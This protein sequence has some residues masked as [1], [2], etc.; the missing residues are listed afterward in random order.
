MLQNE[1]AEA[2]RGQRPITSL[3][4]SGKREFYKPSDGV[5]SEDHT[6]EVMRK[7]SPA[8]GLV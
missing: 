1:E 3:C 4:T 5:L 7:H 6:V 8:V 2:A